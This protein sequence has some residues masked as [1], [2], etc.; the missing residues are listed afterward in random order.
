VR[1]MSLSKK[2]SIIFVFCIAT[3]VASH[4]QTFTTLVNF[5][6][7]NGADPVPQPM[8]QGLDRN[9]YGTTEQGGANHSGTAFKMA[10]TGGLTTLHSFCAATDC[11]DGS[12]PTTII[13]GLDGDFYGTATG[14]GS[15]GMG[16]VYRLTP[17]GRVTTL[18]TFDGPDGFGGGYLLQT[19]HGG[20][21]GTT[22][23]GGTA[24]QCFGAGC[25]TIFRMTSSGALTTLYDFCSQPNCADGEVLFGPVIEDTHGN[26]WGVTFAGGIGNG[27]TIFE[28]P[29]GGELTTIYSFCVQS[30]PFCANYPLWLVIGRDG[31]FYGST[32]MGALSQGTVFKMTPEGVVTTLYSFCAQSGCT[33]GSDPGAGLFLGSD[34]N[35]YGTTIYGGTSNKGTAFEITTAGVLTTLHSFD[36]T[37]G[38]YP[39]GGLFQA[40]NGI[41]YGTTSVGGSGGAGTVYSL[42]TGLAPFV[43]TLPT[44][45]DRGTSV[46]I[47]GTDLTGASSVTFNGTAAKFTVASSS[48]IKTTVPEDATSGTVEVTTPNGTL[49]SNVAFR[50]TK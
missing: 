4:A 18:H 27:G 32:A 19:N 42:D 10:P 24:T 33:D 39:I 21:E 17:S 8:A 26:F 1:K 16:T 37:D 28:I 2:A 20:F 12:T 5:N 44:A 38:N 30:Y 23:F 3:T 41:F 43:E 47:L 29:S 31:N 49:N 40:T 13:L 35:L 7:T 11:N 45:G 46:R 34:G 25:G 14:G 50:V 6:G 48:E 9:L 22:T 15:L 36:G